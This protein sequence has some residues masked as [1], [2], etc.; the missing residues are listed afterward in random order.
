MGKVK[1]ILLGA[2]ARGNIYARYALE[3]PEQFEVVAVAE[4]DDQRRQAFVETFHIPPENVFTNW[5]QLLEKPKMADA[6]MICTMDHMHTEPALKAL[7]LG[8]HVLLE[9]PMAPTEWE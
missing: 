2:G 1:A 5:T 4:P 3:K 6:A 9:K 7:Q 8:Y